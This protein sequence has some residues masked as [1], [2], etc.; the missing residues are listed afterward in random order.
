MKILK[1][2]N[3][4]K[5]ISYIKKFTKERIGNSSDEILDLVASMTI[6]KSI[7]NNKYYINLSKIEKFL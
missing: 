4:E 6:S 5:A 2:E 7:I 3:N 1:F